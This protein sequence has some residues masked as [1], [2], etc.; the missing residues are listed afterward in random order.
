VCVLAGEFKHRDQ[1]FRNDATVRL[2]GGNI[3]IP[4]AKLM[5]ASGLN[6]SIDA[7]ISGARDPPKGTLSYDVVASSD[8]VKDPARSRRWRQ[9]A[10]GPIG[11]RYVGKASFGPSGLGAETRRARM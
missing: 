4:S 3:L 8:A 2:D 9:Y 7:R 10:G 6:I 1:V 11:A 5:M